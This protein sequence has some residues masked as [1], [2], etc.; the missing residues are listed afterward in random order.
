MS[1]RPRLTPEAEAFTD[2]L[3]EVFRVNR[4]LLDAGDEITRP[5][6]LSST[7][8]QVLGLV[9]HGPSTVATVARD[10][11]LTRQSV[12]YAVDTMADEGLVTFAAN[13]HH[14]RSKL[15]A[16]TPKGRAALD[17]VQ[18]RQAAWANA[19][20]ERQSLS[21]LRSATTALRRLRLTLDGSSRDL[22][23]RDP[24]WSPDDQVAVPRSREHRRK[25]ST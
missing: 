25:G 18:R 3:V 21:G 17:N 22:D 2:L 9:E 8:W 23:W 19:I 7:R 4:L 24:K 14:L 20:G 16:I 15:V 5:D 11:G 12:Q 10:M 13:P 6:G 1:G